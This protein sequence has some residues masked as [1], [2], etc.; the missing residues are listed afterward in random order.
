MKT[1][2][3]AVSR[4]FLEWL[5]VHVCDHSLVHNWHN[6]MLIAVI[7]DSKHSCMV[8]RVNHRQIT[9]GSCDRK[10][11]HGFSSTSEIIICGTGTILVCR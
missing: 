6:F 7:S 8:P 10:T 2:D 1:A 5:C 3:L 11:I 4:A 9:D